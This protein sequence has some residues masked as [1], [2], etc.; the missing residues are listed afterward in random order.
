MII[1][2]YSK[3]QDST[4]TF[5]IDWSEWLGTRIIT[6]STWDVGGLT[7]EAEDFTDT[8]TTIQLS[9]GLWTE[10]FT[11]TNTV[12]L[13]STD[14]ESRQLVINIQ[15]EQQYCTI[16]EVRRRGTQFTETAFTDTELLALIEQASRYFDQEAG[17]SAG[18]FNPSPYPIPTDRVFYGDGTHYLKVDTYIADSIVSVD[19]PA[20]YTAPDYVARNGYLLRTGET[21]IL[22]TTMRPWWPWWGGWPE[23]VPVTVN[24]VW[25]LGLT[26][27]D[28]RMAVIELV[29]NLA[30]ETDPAHL[31]LTD[32]ER[33]PLRERIPPRVAAVA[34]R[35]R[36]KVNPAF[37]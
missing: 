12:T 31:N 25:G 10:S 18:Y 13:D 21:H 8:T 35:Y 6:V 9:G 24:A 19:F 14:V 17:V 32:L 22:P 16:T 11:I 26:P 15:Q 1:A 29:I 28:V 27:A 34:R 20:D 23:G 7:I 30:R 5:G 33:Q 2:T 36:L 37:V 3:L 4:T